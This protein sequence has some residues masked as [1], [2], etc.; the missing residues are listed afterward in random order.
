MPLAELRQ[1][2][3]VR[4]FVGGEKAKGYVVIGFGLDLAR[5]VNPVA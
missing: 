3:V 1:R 2:T 4:M 5:T